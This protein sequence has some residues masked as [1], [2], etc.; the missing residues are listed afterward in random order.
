MKIIKRVG[1]CA[2]VALAVSYQGA[3]A[4]ELTGA[5][6]DYA[7]REPTSAVKL[8][9]EAIGMAVA[10][11]VISLAL[12]SS[13]YSVLA[14]LYPIIYDSVTGGFVTEGTDGADPE[15][16]GCLQQ[17]NNRISD[18]ESAFVEADLVELNSIL[19][20]SK[21]EI[22]DLGNLYYHDEIAD[23]YQELAVKLGTTIKNTLDEV[24]EEN[25]VVTKAKYDSL[26][27]NVAPAFVSI[28]QMELLHRREF[29]RFCFNQEVYP[30]WNDISS[31]ELVDPELLKTIKYN[32]SEPL[33]NYLT[34][35]EGSVANCDA[36]YNTFLTFDRVAGD[37]FDSYK[38]V[39]EK[40][41]IF[42][43]ESTKTPGMISVAIDI[44]NSELGAYRELMLT[45]CDNNHKFIDNY[46]SYSYDAIGSSLCEGAREHHI[47]RITPDGV[48][49]ENA[50]FSSE[51]ER[52]HIFRNLAAVV[53]SWDWYSHT[54][55]EGVAQLD[56][57]TL[58]LYE[59]FG[60]PTY[61]GVRLKH[62]DTDLC[63][64]SD[65]KATYICDISQNHFMFRPFEDGYK[66]TRISDNRNFKDKGEDS[67]GFVIR[68]GEGLDSKWIADYEGVWGLDIAPNFINASTGRCLALDEKSNLTATDCDEIASNVWE[69][70]GVDI[71]DT[72][73]WVSMR[74][75]GENTCIGSGNAAVSCE[76]DSVVY[77][78]LPYNGGYRVVRDGKNMKDKGDSGISFLSG[79][80]DVA[81]WDIADWNSDGIFRL[82]NV[83]TNKCLDYV[84]GSLVATGC[85][86]D[87]A[88]SEFFAFDIV[89]LPNSSNAERI[90]LEDNLSISRCLGRRYT[91]NSG[92]GHTAYFN[93]VCSLADMALV[94]YN[95][96]YMIYDIN[97]DKYIEDSDTAGDSYKS[98]VPSSEPSDSTTWDFLGPYDLSG[99]NHFRIRNRATG[100][101]LLTETVSTTTAPALSKGDCSNSTTLMWSIYKEEE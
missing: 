92:T 64:G 1:I 71:P 6:Y 22:I 28:I 56:E 40:L 33:D 11:N 100:D 55:P 8:D 54:M 99:V 49:A 67:D 21:S 79:L 94:K 48:F 61:N 74:H 29:N 50:N 97:N 96:G 16:V 78:I 62:I 57:D 20:R 17:F 73:S 65:A 88:L 60:V 87:P 63:V 90:Y 85:E 93:T 12:G 53:D 25:P 4:A 69:I 42:I 45:E 27:Y 18:L 38:L 35:P 5:C 9:G 47:E 31:N 39:L 51:A 41:G 86:L 7:T 84:N 80:G 3:S 82:R 98:L 91:T 101:C 13:G 76:V 30:T 70:D 10:N 66:I 81:T 89:D 36:G 58:P 83:D 52:N 59:T 19:S 95:G 2:G 68:S 24:Y 32:D 34:T 72:H 37:E 43:A 46:Y 15:L 75:T 23:E 26:V 77:Q 44:Y 14:G